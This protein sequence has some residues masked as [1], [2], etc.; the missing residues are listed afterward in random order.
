MSRFQSSFF[1]LIGDSIESL[2]L[3]AFKSKAYMFCPAAQR[4]LWD[5]LK[6]Y[7]TRSRSWLTKVGHI[8]HRSLFHLKCHEPDSKIYLFSK[9]VY[10]CTQG[11]RSVD[12]PNSAGAQEVSSRA[13]PSLIQDNELILAEKLGSGSFGVVKRGEWHTPTGRVVRF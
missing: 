2:T 9:W 12:E 1:L 13:L 7:K 6:R 10:W 11:S 8:Y 3:N 5:A 4:R